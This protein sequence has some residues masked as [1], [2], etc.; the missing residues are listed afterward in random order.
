[1]FMSPKY[2]FNLD[3]VSL[4][5]LYKYLMRRYQKPQKC[6]STLGLPLTLSNLVK[7]NYIFVYSSFLKEVI[8]LTLVQKKSFWYFQINVFNKVKMFK[9]KKSSI[10]TPNFNCYFVKILSIPA[11][12]TIFFHGYAIYETPYTTYTNYG[13]VSLPQMQFP[14]KKQTPIGASLDKWKTNICMARNCD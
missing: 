13:I 2:Q 9:K 7:L 8:I 10:S 1:M 6:N 14:C 4:A 5:C 12:D 3:H 11:Q